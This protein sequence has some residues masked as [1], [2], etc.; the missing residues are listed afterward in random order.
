MEKVQRWVNETKGGHYVTEKVKRS[1]WVPL[2][3]TKEQED[4]VGKQKRLGLKGFSKF[5]R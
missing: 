2:K 4:C 1:K 5:S 3:R